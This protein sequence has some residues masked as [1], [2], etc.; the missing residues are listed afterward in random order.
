MNINSF[1]LYKS[2]EWKA[3]DKIN[4][5]QIILVAEG[6]KQIGSILW[7]GGSNY[8][9]YYNI[10]VEANLEVCLTKLGITWWLNPIPCLEGQNSIFF[11]ISTNDTR[12]KFFKQLLYYYEESMIDH[13][14]FLEVYLSYLDTPNCCIK[15]TLSD[16]NKSVGSVPNFFQEI[17][18]L[19]SKGLPYPD[20]FNY[21]PPNYTP[22]S[23]SC[24][25]SIEKLSKWKDIVN[26]VDKDAG[27]ALS[28][29]NKNF[30][31]SSFKGILGGTSS[32]DSL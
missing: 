18:D 19:S 6:V 24:S 1:D 11:D 4:R 25:E 14:T 12:K 8:S 9:Y 16:K 23:I 31:F 32:L 21:L 2:A 17:K 26:S 30:S 20:V 15:E 29:F 3:L 5:S 28:N 7:R 22:C 27:D 13:E 10:M